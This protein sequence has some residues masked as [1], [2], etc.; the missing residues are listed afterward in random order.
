MTTP[1]ICA[2][3][4]RRDGEHERLRARGGQRLGTNGHQPLKRAPAEQ[5]SNRA[6]PIES[7]I[8]GA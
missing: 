4:D 5:V 1:A 6:D 3:M 8:Q 2:Q 7:G